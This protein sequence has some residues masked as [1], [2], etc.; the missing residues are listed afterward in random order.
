MIWFYRKL[1]HHNAYWSSY[2]PHND[3][4]KDFLDKLLVNRNHFFWDSIVLHLPRSSIASGQRHSETRVRARREHKTESSE[5]ELPTVKNRMTKLISKKKK[6]NDIISG[7]RGIQ[8]LILKIKLFSYCGWSENNFNA[9]SSI[10][11]FSPAKITFPF[12]Q[13]DVVSHLSTKWGKYCVQGTW[14]LRSFGK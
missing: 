3:F 2:T 5:T 13:I 10:A 14:V 8:Q 12:M 9:N 6:C 1:Q 4:T 7:V 11:S